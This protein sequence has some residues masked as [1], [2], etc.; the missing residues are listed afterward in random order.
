[1]DLGSVPQLHT[2]HYIVSTAPGTALT[3]VQ[4]QMLRQCMSPA[5]ESHKGAHSQWED[6]L[7]LLILECG[8]GR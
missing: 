4:A 5:E 3:C 7:W 8:G 6:C 2:H 1:M